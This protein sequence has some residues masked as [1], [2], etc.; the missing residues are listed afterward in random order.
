LPPQLKTGA[1][2]CKK[3]SNFFVTP[4]MFPKFAVLF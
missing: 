3:T 4:E 2:F 1:F